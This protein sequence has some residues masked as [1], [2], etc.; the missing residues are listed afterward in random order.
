M[1]LSAVHRVFLCIPI[2]GF[3]FTS[4]A[5]VLVTDEFCLN[6]ECI[7][8]EFCFNSFLGMKKISFLNAFK[9]KATLKLYSSWHDDRF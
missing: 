6:Y 7:W 8:V 5:W 4:R 3:F 9:I 2:L 1:F